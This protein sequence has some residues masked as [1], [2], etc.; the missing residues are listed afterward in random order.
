MRL[1]IAITTRERLMLDED[2]DR[3]ELVDTRI[4]R[5][6]CTRPLTA[7]AT[8]INIRNVCGSLVRAMR[9]TNQGRRDAPGLSSR[10]NRRGIV[11]VAT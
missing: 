9:T 7:A 4:E 1:A 3:M 6:R 10:N 8:G 11:R 5:G 2:G